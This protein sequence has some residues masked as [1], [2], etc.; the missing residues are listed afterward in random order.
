VPTGS[1]LVFPSGF[2]SSGI[3]GTFSAKLARCFRNCK[4]PSRLRFP[5][6]RRWVVAAR[7]LNV[8][9][10]HMLG[11]EAHAGAGDG[12][13]QVAVC[14]LMP[15]RRRNGRERMFNF[16]CL[17]TFVKRNGQWSR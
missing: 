1:F 15:L 5:C 6:P 7:T 2:P 4:S 8:G 17:D 16:G 10:F 3:S 13:L 11:A 14:Q 9:S 12:R